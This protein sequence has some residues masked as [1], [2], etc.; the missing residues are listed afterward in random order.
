MEQQVLEN[1]G[2]SV[3]YEELA[4]G[5]PRE[6]W[7]STGFSAERAFK[8]AW[9]DVPAFAEDIL[10]GVEVLDIAAGD[11]TVTRGQPYPRFEYARADAVDVR[12]LG[13]NDA[14]TPP[15]P[16]TYSHAICIV[17]YSV[18][19]NTLGSGATNDT[20][21]VTE[22]L[23]P[24]TEFLTMPHHKLYWTYTGGSAADPLTREQAPAKLITCLNWNYTIHS[25]PRVPMAFLTQ[26]GT[27]N[28]AVV[29]SPTLGLTWAAETLLFNGPRLQR[30]IHRSGAR[31]WTVEMSFTYRPSTWNKFQ[32]RADLAAAKLLDADGNEV[33]VYTP[34]DFNNLL[35]F[36]PGV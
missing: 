34:S 30:E 5:Y 6:R 17:S 20:P 3:T 26:V 18:P 1:S 33:D 15:D 23:E 9:G 16:L 32:R 31:V 27:V 13:K 7:G 24:M 28:D 25:M 29:T 8:I 21:L 36:P 11:F 22:S 14:V 12:P 4:D 19:S 2:T 10:G 35:V